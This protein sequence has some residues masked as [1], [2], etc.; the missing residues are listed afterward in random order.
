[1]I[2]LLEL[3]VFIEEGARVPRAPLLPRR[4]VAHRSRRR[5]TCERLSLPYSGAWRPGLREPGT[6]LPEGP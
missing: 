4:R 6:T 2:G 5:T 1:M 3:S